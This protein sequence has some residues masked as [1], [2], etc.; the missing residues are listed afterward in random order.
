[1]GPVRGPGGTCRQKWGRARIVS[2]SQLCGVVLQAVWEDAKAL[3]LVKGGGVRGV[4]N[5]LI[6]ACG[7]LE[8]N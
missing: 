6:Y 2:G 4:S 3:V 1:V 5:K 7:V 8:I